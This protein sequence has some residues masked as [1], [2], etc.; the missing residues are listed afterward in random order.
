MG[1][2]RIAAIAGI[3]LVVAIA[4]ALL[5][6]LWILGIPGTKSAPYAEGWFIGYAAIP[7]YL[8][9]YGFGLLALG[10]LRLFRWPGSRLVHG[11]IWV[12]LL[13]F[14]VAM[15]ISAGKIF[16]SEQQAGISEALEKRTLGMGSEPGHWRVAGAA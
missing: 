3:P 2:V 14:L 1:A 4:A 11:L 15:G 16:W 10:M 9:T 5:Y 6:P 8:A 7:A 12:C 13:C